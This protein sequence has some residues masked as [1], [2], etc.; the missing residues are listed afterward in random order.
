LAKL[1]EDQRLI[2]A[3]ED[4]LLEAR[5]KQ[6]DEVEPNRMLA[7][8]YARRVT[9][10]VLHRQELQKEPQAP[11]NPGEPDENGVY[12]IGGPVAPPTRVE[13]PYPSEALAAGVQG[14]VIVQ[15]VVDPSGTVTDATVVRSI[16]LLDAAA[17]QAA[18]NW[19]FAPTVVNGQAVPLML[20]IPVNFVPPP[21]RAAPPRP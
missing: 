3:A 5:H 7:Q 8:F 16:P 2:D 19:H 13:A 18:F 20:K 6:P 4:T 9:V 17:L 15:V 21:T 10:T 11:G 14:V 12:R 1:Q